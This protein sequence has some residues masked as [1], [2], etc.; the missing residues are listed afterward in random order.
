MRK[1]VAM[2]VPENDVRDDLLVARVVLDLR[3]RLEEMPLANHRLV[4]V[5]LIADEAVP[6]S[7]R[8]D[9]LTLHA[10]DLL[11]R[12][13][14]AGATAIRTRPRPNTAMS[15]AVRSTSSSVT[16]RKYIHAARSV[17]VVIIVRAESALGLPHGPS[18]SAMQI[19]PARF[20]R[21]LPMPVYMS[22]SVPSLR[23]SSSPRIF[24]RS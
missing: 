1:Q 17:A 18:A 5:E 8:K 13:S 9:V 4:P 14:H 11:G 21:S 19:R 22:P 24:S 10:Q 20:T 12:R 6:R 3:P 2:A 23:T 7:I 16:G 15:S